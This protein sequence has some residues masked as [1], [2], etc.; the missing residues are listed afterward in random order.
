MKYYLIDMADIVEEGLPVIEAAFA[1]WREN[2]QQEYSSRGLEFHVDHFWNARV[3]A[4][5][6]NE[7]E[8]VGV[9]LYN[10][11]DLRT[12]ITTNHPYFGDISQDRLTDFKKQGDLRLM[13]MEYLLV[14]PKYRG[15]SSP[16]RWGEVVI[17]LGF[18][19]LLSSSWDAAIGIGREDKKVNLMAAKMG[20]QQAEQLVKNDTPCRVLFMSRQDY[21]RHE[22]PRVRELIA[23][24]WESKANLAG[25]YFVSPQAE[26][27]K[28]VA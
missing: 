18:L 17:G 1:L 26:V 12:S 19:F 2:Y 24:L 22:D 6:L 11:Y 21:K 27:S 23:E 20:C 3:L 15:K 10:S 13:S 25:K 28:S 5:I 14:N 4:V 16:V 8:V 9:H 7:N